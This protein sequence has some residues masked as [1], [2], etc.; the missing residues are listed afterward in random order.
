ME[1]GVR[2]ALVHIRAVCGAASFLSPS[3]LST[4]S[5]ATPLFHI[6]L[7]EYELTKS[8]QK[9]A[10]SFVAARLVQ[11]LARHA[12]GSGISEIKCIISGFVM[13]GFLG[14]WTFLIKS[15]TLVSEKNETISGISVL[16]LK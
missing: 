7:D 10:L 15:L 3:S 11:S 13:E 14:F 8:T 12:A 5:H 4:L 9:A 1:Y 2:G 6:F 16:N